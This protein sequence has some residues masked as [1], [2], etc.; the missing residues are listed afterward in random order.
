ML[1]QKRRIRRRCQEGRQRHQPVET[2]NVGKVDK[3]G[4][5]GTADETDLHAIRQPREDERRK[6]PFAFQFG[7]DRRR[8]KPR[9]QR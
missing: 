5:Q 3:A 4:G 8:R 9:R 1:Q 7:R 6:V 2:D